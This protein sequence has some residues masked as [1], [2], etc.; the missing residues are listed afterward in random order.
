MYAN[1]QLRLPKDGASWQVTDK[2]C[3]ILTAQ[4]Q[5]I[6][7]H[8]THARTQLRLPKDGASWQVADKRWD[9]LTAQSQRIAW[10]TH[11][12]TH[13]ELHRPKDGAF[14]QV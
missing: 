11:A 9:I 10:N 12:P 8:N 7:T 4:S 14:W 2:R 13:I 5:H 6:H 3:D 1:M